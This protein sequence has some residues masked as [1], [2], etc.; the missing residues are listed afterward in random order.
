MLSNVKYT[1]TFISNENKPILTYKDYISN[2][3]LLKK[4]KVKELKQI[5]RL[6]KL[7]VSGKKF[8]L[9][10]RIE[11]LF[12]DNYCCIQIQKL[13]RGFIVRQSFK[14][15]GKGFYHR[16]LCVNE[17]DF[18][19]LEPLHEIPFEYFYTFTC[20]KFV[21]G[22]NIISLIYLIKSKTVVK[23]PYNRES[24]SYHVIKEIIRLYSFIKIIFGL[25]EDSP[26]INN[27]IKNNNIQ[28]RQSILTTVSII[29]LREQKMREVFS[30]SIHERI[31]EL[32]IEI[33]HLGNYTQSTWFS[34]LD[35]RQYIILFRTLYDIWN[36]RGQLS[37][38]TRLSI[39]VLYDPFIEL[40]R[41]QPLYWH[42]V[43]I[44]AVRERCLKIMEYMVY[45]GIDD[46]YR[47]IGA[48]HVLTALTNVSTN[49]RY[50]MPWLYEALI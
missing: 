39:C 48:L 20:N 17:S 6:N 13:F 9:F 42:E 44:E 18:Y 5:A 43:S 10:K 24:L 14:M 34:N 7:H 46:E 32:F 31:Q 16:K 27:D 1:N 50:A 47:K 35:R 15:R 11:T 49:A 30:K 3:S 28:L 45:C 21:Y 40:T 41:E 37:R 12:L 19:S 2:R 8:D 25:P 23:N 22:C 38:Q 4:C 26:L 33:D 29:E 36:F